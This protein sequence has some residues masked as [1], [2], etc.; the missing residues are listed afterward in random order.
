VQNPLSFL[1]SAIRF[2][3][4]SLELKTSNEQEREDSMVIYC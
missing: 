1:Y 4:F 2:V 3:R